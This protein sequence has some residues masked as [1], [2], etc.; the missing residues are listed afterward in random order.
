MSTMWVGDIASKLNA[1]RSLGAAA[2]IGIMAWQM[3]HGP[4]ATRF[5]NALFAKADLSG[6]VWIGCWSVEKNQ[7]KVF[8]TLKFNHPNAPPLSK[9]LK[10]DWVRP[11]KF[12]K[13]CQLPNSTTC[14]FQ[15]FV[16]VSSII[17]KSG[18]LLVD[19]LWFQLKIWN[20]NHILR[21][22][23]NAC[24]MGSVAPQKKIIYDVQKQ[25]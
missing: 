24:L 14:F 19:V 10:S 1:S 6:V 18:C 20:S 13:E 21:E 7:P 23:K 16:V 4:L 3:S 15:L 8:W 5:G 17:A 12:L 2:N 9:A 22:E 25:T 11:K